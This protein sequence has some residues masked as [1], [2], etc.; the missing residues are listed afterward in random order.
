MVKTIY[1][2]E[3]CT[4]RLGGAVVDHKGYFSTLT[5]KLPVFLSY[6]LLHKLAVHPALVPWNHRSHIFTISFHEK[7]VTCR[8]KPCLLLELLPLLILETIVLSPGAAM[9]GMKRK[10]LQLFVQI[11]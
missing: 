2:F 6:L 8:D 11:R 9:N 4:F 10:I 3:V 1:G 7:L 5:L